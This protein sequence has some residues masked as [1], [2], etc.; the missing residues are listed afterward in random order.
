MVRSLA[1]FADQVNA[2]SLVVFR[3]IFRQQPGEFHQAKLTL[4][5]IAIL[6]FLNRQ[7]KSKMTGLAHF[8]NVTTA[9]MTGIVERLVRDGYLA[10]E[11]DP[12][13]RRVIKVKLT[14]KGS[15]AVKS[16]IEQ[17]RQMIMNIFGKISQGERE[18]YLR[19]LAHIKEHLE[20]EARKL[21]QVEHN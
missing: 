17:K 14:V 12:F 16:L 15:H 13:D 19:I 6:E 10:R 2:T 9:C 4:P 21:K 20:G 7:G 8:A 1:E 3:E 11:S 18:E 5:Q